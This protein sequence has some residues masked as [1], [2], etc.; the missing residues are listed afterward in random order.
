MSLQSEAG[1]IDYEKSSTSPKGDMLVPRY[2]KT[3]R[4][5]RED[6]GSGEEFLTNFDS[7]ARS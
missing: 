7:K 5:Y 2:Q 3:D 1:R 4:K 6:Q